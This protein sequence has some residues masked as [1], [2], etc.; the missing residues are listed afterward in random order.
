MH[1]QCAL[2]DGYTWLPGPEFNL[3]EIYR[4][5]FRRVL[6]GVKL[7]EHEH[8]MNFSPVHA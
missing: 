5:T 4:I 7:Q 6:T 3:H 2:P 1:V 8:V